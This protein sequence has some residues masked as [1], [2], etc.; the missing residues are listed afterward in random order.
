MKQTSQFDRSLFQKWTA[1]FFV[2][3]IAAFGMVQA[4]HIHSEL[5]PHGGLNESATHC[6]LCLATHS[7]ATITEAD[8]TPIPVVLSAAVFVGRSQAKSRLAV[9][10]LFIRPPPA[11]L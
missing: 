1:L 3:V 6:S 11:T 5:A 4:V 9:P 10:T 2:L 8:P 7:A